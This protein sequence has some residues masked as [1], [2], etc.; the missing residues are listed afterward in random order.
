VDVRVISAT[1]QDLGKAIAE[2]HFRQDLYYRIKGVE[3]FVPPLRSRREDVVLLANYFLDRLVQKN[4]AATARRFSTNAI[5]ALLAHPWPGNVRELEHTVTAAATMSA[6]AEI[7]AA[8]LAIAS[9][10]GGQPAEEAAGDRHRHAGRPAADGS[11]GSTGGMVRAA[12]DRAGT[13][14][15][16]QQHQR[17]RPAARAASAELAAEDGPIGAGTRAS[18]NDDA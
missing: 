18:G 11:E 3:L 10:S 2:G 5:D 4:P 1:H 15:V 6:A 13:G 14:Q 7:R 9:S 16:R 8:D 12:G 17:R